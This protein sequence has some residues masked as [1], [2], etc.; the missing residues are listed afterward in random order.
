MLL[1]LLACAPPSEDSAAPLSW[2]DAVELEAA[3]AHL[4]VL[5]ALAAESGGDRAF[6]HPGYEAAVDYAAGV[7]EGAGFQVTLQELSGGLPPATSW[8][9]LAAW[10]APPP[11]PALLIGGHLDSI[12]GPG[13]NDNGS[14]AAA[15]LELAV[16]AATSGRAEEAPLRFAL[17]AGEE[18]GLLGSRYYTQELDEAG[19][20]GLLAYLNLDMIASQNGVRG[21]WTADE[22]EGAAE[23][24]AA[25]G[26]AFEAAD[27]DWTLITPSQGSSDHFPFA[28]IGVPGAGL[29]AGSSDE[30]TQ[31][32]A[33]R[34]G[35]EAGVPYE[36]CYHDPCDDLSNVD[37]A[38][39]EEM[40]YAAALAADGL[41]G[42]ETLSPQETP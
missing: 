37:L 28:E 14:G 6:G 3:V 5:E 22:G 15:V 13:L 10:P 24:T 34:F 38:L 2:P 12:D 33:E 1:L 40:L 19:R 4:E 35:G 17:W 18:V 9:V 7:L 41:A 42:R 32:E 20:A 25:L 21:V 29:F 8:N 39:L 26:E 31:E 11:G 27:L 36:D 16:R 30:K 23:V